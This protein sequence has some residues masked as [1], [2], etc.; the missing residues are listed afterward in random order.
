MHRSR[1][2]L[3][4]RARREDAPWAAA[5]DTA[6]PTL[7]RLL[8]SGLVSTVPALPAAAD[9]AVYSQWLL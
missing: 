4:Q 1:A 2:V 3:E 6:H 8:R 5:E 9:T 7:A